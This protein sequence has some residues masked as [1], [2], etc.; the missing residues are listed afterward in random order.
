MI[1]TERLILRPYKMT[2]LKDYYEYVSQPNVGPRCGWKPYDNI[3][4]AK[5]RL[6]HETQKQYQLAIYL[7]EENKVIGSIEIMNIKPDRWTDDINPD[8]TRELGALLHENYWN[9]G[10]MTE[11][12]RAAIKFCFDYLNMERVVAG[13][14][15][16][17]IGSGKMQQKSGMQ[18]IGRVPNYINW[19][20]TETPCDL[21]KTMI[22]K[23]QYLDNPI[24]KDVKIIV[25][26]N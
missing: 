5:E 10:I 18:I 8:T 1:Q 24:Y 22:T 14:Y 11:A 17:N 21:I 20:T 19:Y 7:K 13:F 3:E 15:E 2:D 4:K 9:K 23:Q 6:E 25:E 16:P 12:V 26:N